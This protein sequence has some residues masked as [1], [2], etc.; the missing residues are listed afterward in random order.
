MEVLRQPLAE[1]S[2][3]VCRANYNDTYPAAFYLSRP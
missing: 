2:I 1:R 3:T